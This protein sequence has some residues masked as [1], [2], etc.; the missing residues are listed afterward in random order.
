MCSGNFD[1]WH[2]RATS[3]VL[4]LVVFGCVWS[5][6]SADRHKWTLN[7][8]QLQE[9]NPCMNDASSTC[10]IIIDV[11]SRLKTLVSTHPVTGACRV[12]NDSRI[13]IR[14]AQVVSP[15]LRS[16][17]CVGTVAHSVVNSCSKRPPLC[18]HG[19]TSRTSTQGVKLYHVIHVV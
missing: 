1:E 7:L 14:L 11:S 6:G 3:A 10:H 12:K 17:W 8:A 13:V 2:L 19:V 16:F 15:H 5:K 18:A 4:S 9:Y